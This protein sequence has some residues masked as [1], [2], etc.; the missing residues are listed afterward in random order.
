MYRYL[1]NPALVPSCTVGVYATSSRD[2]IFDGIKIINLLG[3]KTNAPNSQLTNAERVLKSTDFKLFSEMVQ[4]MERAVRKDGIV[5]GKNGKELTSLKQATLIDKEIY[6]KVNHVLTAA[7]EVGANLGKV[8]RNTKDTKYI[9]AGDFVYLSRKYRNHKSLGGTFFDPP[10]SDDWTTQEIKNWFY[11]VPQDTKIPVTPGIRRAIDVEFW[12][13]IAAGD[14]RG[15]NVFCQREEQVS[16]IRSIPNIFVYE[17]GWVMANT[18]KDRGKSF[19]FGPLLYYSAMQ[20]IRD[21]AKRLRKEGIEVG[22]AR[23]QGVPVAIMSDRSDTVSAHAQRFWSGLFERAMSGKQIGLFLLPK[24]CRHISCRDMLDYQ[25]ARG[26]DLVSEEASFLNYGFY[27][28]RDLEISGVPVN[29]TASSMLFEAWQNGFH[30]LDGLS[31]LGPTYEDPLDTVYLHADLIMGGGVGLS[32]EIKNG[33]EEWARLLYRSIS[34]S[35]YVKCVDT[36]EPRRFLRKKVYADKGP[37]RDMPASQRARID[38]ARR[39]AARREAARREVKRPVTSDRFSEFFQDTETRR[40]TEEE[41]PLT[42]SD[43]LFSEEE[44]E[45]LLGANDLGDVRRPLSTDQLDELIQ[46]IQTRNNPYGDDY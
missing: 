10:N 29:V 37:I 15:R 16:R 3:P 28:K 5:V 44:L 24:K 6:L 18:L 38:A 31:G 35:K 34:A 22:W 27:A 20:A 2:G 30:D 41:R 17:T 39:E 45:D 4:E 33:I 14:L 11:D 21:T 12:A 13:S 23:S 40:Q 42:K 25:N 46:T 7:Y 9:L 36:L 26:I 19:S 8:Y 1:N 43:V 32:R